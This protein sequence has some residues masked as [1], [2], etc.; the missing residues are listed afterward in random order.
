M[1]RAVAGEDCVRLTISDLADTAREEV[2]EVSLGSRPAVTELVFGVVQ[3]EGWGG[4]LKA[5]ASLHVGGCAAPAVDEAAQNF[6]VGVPVAQV[7]FRLRSLAG[8]DGGVDAGALDGGPGDAGAFDAGPLD[9]GA[10]DAGPP[11][12][13]APDAGGM[14]AGQPDAGPM[15]AGQPDAGGMDAG[16]PDAGACTGIVR[17]VR[18]SGPK[19]TDLALFSSQGVI[20]VGEGDAI[21]LF[22]AANSFTDWSGGTCTGN[23]YGVWVR[24]TDFQPFVVNSNGIRRVDGPGQCPALASLPAGNPQALSGIRIGGVTRLYVPTVS[25]ATVVELD[26]GQPSAIARTPPSAGAVY[27]VDGVDEDTLFAVGN[28]TQNDKG[29]FWRWNVTAQAWDTPTALAPASTPVYAVDVVS[30]VLAFAGGAGGL[31]QWNG[32]SWSSVGTPGFVVYGVRALSATE[33]YVVGPATG[34]GV[35]F[36]RWNGSG[37]SSP[38]RPASS[39]YLARVR[40]GAACGL[41]AVGDSGLVVTTEP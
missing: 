24:P 1:E 25:P 16:Q 19:W 18:T 2:R 20:A 7:R 14:D 37:F 29:A 12:A 39:A 40:G 36:A 41:W 33:V 26:V 11:D 4:L 6:S 15:D 5:S 13:G 35:S 23:F 22:T 28:T 38:V 31:Y 10:T 32:A 9:A 17:A 27:D 21:G 8:A 3:P 34:A 30:S